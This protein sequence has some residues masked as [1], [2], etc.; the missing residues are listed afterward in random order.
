MP[1][2]TRI[3]HRGASGK[4]WAPENTLVAFQKAIEIGTDAIEMDV[5]RTKDGHVVVC[6]DT[7][8][9]RTT[10]R[11]GAIKDLTLSEIKQ[12]DAGNR[13][14]PA[15]AGERIPT[16]KEALDLVQDK[17]LALIEIKPEDIAREVV[18]T[19]EAHDAVERVVV[20]SFHKEVVREVGILNPHLRRAL[21]IGVPAI[22]VGRTRAIR[23]TRRTTEVGASILSLSHNAATPKLVQELHRRGLTLWGWTVDEFDDLRRMLQI[24]VDGII[25]NYPDRLNEVLQSP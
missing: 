6:H 4:G 21:L 11:H 24:G 3:A 2:I 18:R 25:S 12:A 10:D 23:L 16:L 14:G 5:H 19:I 1:N 17:A 8:L 7:T 13:F 22:D 20:Q 15:F 9:D